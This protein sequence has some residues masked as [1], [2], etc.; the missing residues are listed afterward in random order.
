MYRNFSKILP[1][2]LRDLKDWTTNSRIKSSQLLHSLLYHMEDSVTHHVQLV[3]DGLYK[4]SQDEEKSVVE[5][6]C[7][8]AQLIGKYTVILT[9]P[10]YDFGGEIFSQKILQNSIHDKIFFVNNHELICIH[11][12]LSHYF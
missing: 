6:S 2:I 3:L 1:A 4:S 11:K 12:N 7:K 10:L 9:I 5:W 8:S